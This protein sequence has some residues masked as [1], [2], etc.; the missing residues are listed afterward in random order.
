[1]LLSFFFRNKHRN[2]LYIPSED[3]QCLWHWATNKVS[4][5]SGVWQ[6]MIL[7]FLSLSPFLDDSF[8][9]EDKNNG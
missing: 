1:M 2:P 4:M 5:S 6:E 3:V 9:N 7:S 8:Q